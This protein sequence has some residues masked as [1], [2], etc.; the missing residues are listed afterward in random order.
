M[1]NGFAAR[2]HLLAYLT[3]S[4]Q[5]VLQHLLHQRTA[6]RPRQVVSETVHMHAL[7]ILYLQGYM[8]LVLSYLTFCL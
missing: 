7:H 1:H 8:Q 4:L 3:V 6:L 5:Q 2:L